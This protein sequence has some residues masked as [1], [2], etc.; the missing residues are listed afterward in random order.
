MFHRVLIEAVVRTL[1]VKKVLLKVSQNSQK[2]TCVRVLVLQGLWV[3]FCEFYGIFKKISGGYFWPK[4][5][6]ESSEVLTRKYYFK[7]WEISQNLSDISGWKISAIYKPVISLETNSFPF[8][9][10]FAHPNI[11]LRTFPSFT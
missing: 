2:Y 9:E 4:Y 10:F 6:S 1:P 3:L 7:Q 11:S 8:Q 5:V